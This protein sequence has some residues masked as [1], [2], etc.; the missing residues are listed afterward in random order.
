MT[1]FTE[2]IEFWILLEV[3]V[4]GVWRYTGSH[5]QANSFIRGLAQQKRN[6]GKNQSMTD[7]DDGT[8]NDSSRERVG[9]V[10]EASDM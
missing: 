8:M 1:W 10:N 4:I 6:G 7:I 5:A 9:P 3:Y 2:Y